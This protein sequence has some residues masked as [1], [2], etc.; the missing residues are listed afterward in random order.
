MLVLKQKSWYPTEIPIDPST[1][2]SII[3]STRLYIHLSRP[4][5][6]FF[7]F[8]GLVCSIHV[9]VKKTICVTFDFCSTIRPFSVCSFSRRRR[10]SPYA[11]VRHALCGQTYWSGSVA[12]ALRLERSGKKRLHHTMEQPRR[13]A[14]E[15]VVQ[16]VGGMIFGSR[17]PSIYPHDTRPCTIPTLP[18][19]RRTFENP[20]EYVLW[21]MPTT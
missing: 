4:A 21:R 19:L 13:G 11:S 9:H 3:H 17:F 1:H 2:A 20:P 15:R 7:F 12:G 18:L 10:N 8:Y 5:T 14:R 16:A 6:F